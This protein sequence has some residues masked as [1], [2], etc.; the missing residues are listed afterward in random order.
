MKRLEKARK[1]EEEKARKEAERAAAAATAP[2]KEKVEE[3]P[4]EPSDPREYF[5]SRVRYIEEQRAKNINPFPHKYHVSISLPEF[6]KKYEY[7]EAGTTLEDVTESVTGLSLY[8][9]F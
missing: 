8:L 3:K 1:K 5:N 2:K 4:S 6:L 9:F 7:L